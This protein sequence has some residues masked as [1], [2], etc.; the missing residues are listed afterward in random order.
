MFLPTRCRCGAAACLRGRLASFFTH[1]CEVPARPPLLLTP[2]TLKG[3]QL[4]GFALGSRQIMVLHSGAGDGAKAG[5]QKTGSAKKKVGTASAALAEGL[6]EV[7]REKQARAPAELAKAQRVLGDL[8]EK[9]DPLDDID[10]DDEA[11]PLCAACLGKPA[12]VRKALAAPNVNPNVVGS[13]GMTPLFQSCQDGKREVVALLLAAKANPGQACFGGATPLY[14]ACARNHADVAK[15]L[16]RAGAPVDALAN[17]Y[18]TPLLACVSHGAEDAARVL[19]AAGADVRL[20]SPKWG[21]YLHA[22]AKHGASSTVQD[23][24]SRQRRKLPG[25]GR[26]WPPAARGAPA[27]A[28]GSTLGSQ[29]RAWATW[30]AWAPRCSPE[31]S[32]RRRQSRRFGRVLPPRQERC[33]AAAAGVRG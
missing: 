31:A 22:A 27:L 14:A 5:A 7:Q 28:H 19:L 16:L 15:L 18:Y 23:A 25:S 33:G 29:S 11:D 2:P 24:P 17:G 21:T 32:A 3:R 10:S 26:S 9:R 30:A 6:R 12:A 4:Q 20:T 1:R 8:V 13:A